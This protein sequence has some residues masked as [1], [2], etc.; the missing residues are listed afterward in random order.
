M[1]VS[2]ERDLRSHF[3]AARDQ[4]ARPTCLAFAVSDFHAALR[5]GW[6]SLSCEFIFYHAQR[7]AHRKPTEGADLTSILEALREDGQPVETD[8]PYLISLPSDLR[9]W[10]PPTEIGPRFRR[11]GAPRGATFQEVIEILEEGSPALI[12]MT[13]SDSFYL[14]R[15]GGV[16]LPPSSESV[17]PTR[18]HAVVAV[19]YGVAD[20]DSAILIR[21]SWGSAWGLDGYAW[22]PR[23]YLEP[24]L[25]RSAVLREEIDVL[26]DSAST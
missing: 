7:R 11:H 6:I 14:P 2:V 21:N 19:G 8:W 10:S 5:G 12:L 15:A 24:R 23:P 25:L 18:R 22:L 26:A 1:V 13:L 16:V 17:D 3:G 20:G 4:G 9:T